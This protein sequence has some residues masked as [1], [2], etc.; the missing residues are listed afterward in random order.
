MTPFVRFACILL[1]LSAVLPARAAELRM[2]TLEAVPWATFSPGGKPV[3]AFPDIVDEIGRR[4]G[5][6]TTVTIQPFQRIERELETGEQDCTIVLWNDSRARIVERGESVYMMTFGVIARTGI[7]LRSYDDLKGLTVSV[8]RNLT[9]EPRF[10]N[11]SSIRKDFDK[12]YETGIKKIAHNRLDAIAGAIP[13]IM[14]QAKKDGLTKYLG[15]QIV[16]TQIPLT[17]QC[18]KASR[19]LTLMPRLDEAI[20]AMRADGTLGRILAAYEYR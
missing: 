4:T 11:D 3:G 14:Y 6:K 18:S 20:R 2:I 19:N 16:M 9:I 15:D 7:P 8:F 17:L 12:D 1:G 5:L 13:T 10:D